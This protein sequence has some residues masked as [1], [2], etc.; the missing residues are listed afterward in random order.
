LEWVDGTIGGGGKQTKVGLLTRLDGLRKTK[1][2]L[3]DPK[4]W[5]E[6]VWLTN[7]HY[8]FLPLFMHFLIFFKI[9]P[10]C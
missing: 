8:I 5:T 1:L 2:D 10:D 7:Q 6:E 4:L 9:I 3:P